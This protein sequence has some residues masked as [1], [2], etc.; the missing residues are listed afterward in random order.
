MNTCD[1]HLFP[2]I[3]HFVWFRIKHT[4]QGYQLFSIPDDTWSSDC[5]KKVVSDFRK[6]RDC[7][8]RQWA[9]ITE[10]RVGR[11]GWLGRRAEL[12][13]TKGSPGCHLIEARGSNMTI[14]I[15]QSIH[16]IP[17][18]SPPS[19]SGTLIRRWSA[20]RRASVGSAAPRCAIIGLNHNVTTSQINYEKNR[21]Q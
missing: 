16:R 13:Q 11:S 20:H 5:L 7:A 8:A 21:L 18:P 12:G 1:S 15:G 19:D 17:I 9:I 3:S 10:C 4:L 2:P 14:S 6:R